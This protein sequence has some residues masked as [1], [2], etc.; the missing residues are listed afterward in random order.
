MISPHDL[1]K[2]HYFGNICTKPD[3]RTPPRCFLDASGLGG[4]VDPRPAKSSST[5]PIAAG[6]N[7]LVVIIVALACSWLVPFLTTPLAHRRQHTIS[8]NASSITAHASDGLRRA[9]DNLLHAIGAQAANKGLLARS[10]EG[11]V[12]QGKIVGCVDDGDGKVMS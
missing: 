2:I 1:E 5:V 9:N 8:P 12:T 7:P 11:A 10:V 6:A 3:P 4:R